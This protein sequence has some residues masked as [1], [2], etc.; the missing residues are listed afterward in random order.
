MEILRDEKWRCQ[1]KKRVRRACDWGYGKGGDTVRAVRV[2][3]SM[4]ISY[5]QL[6]GWL[7]MEYKM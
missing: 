1:G 5:K 4:I 7:Y 6:I 3:A 2:L